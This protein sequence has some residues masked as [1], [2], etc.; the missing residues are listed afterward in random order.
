MNNTLEILQ[1]ILGDIGNFSLVI[2]GFSATLFTVF[3]SFILNKKEV[4]KELSNKIRIDN[5]PL[6]SQM[7][8]NAILYI[9]KMKKMNI[10]VI[11]SL[12]ISLCVYVTSIIVKYFVSNQESKESLIR[13]LSLCS[14]LII[15]YIISMLITT[16]KSYMK[17]TKTKRRCNK[18]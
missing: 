10:H 1:N 3:Y 14:L 5:D 6:L 15:L 16:V 4:L 12:F 11:I 8:S 13:V 17:T 18:R 9:R 7:E 2:F